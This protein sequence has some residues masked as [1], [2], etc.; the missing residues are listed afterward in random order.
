MQIWMQRHASRGGPGAVTWRMRAADTATRRLGSSRTRG[1]VLALVRSI[2]RQLP[3]AGVAACFFASGMAGLVYEVVWTRLL[4]LLFGHTVHAVT[5]VLA[6]Y[7]G[8]L[9]LGSLLLGRWADRVRRPLRA[10]AGLDALVGAYCAATP[11]LLSAADGAYLRLAR[12]ANPSGAAAL[13]LQFLLAAALLAVPT[14][15]MGATLPV[16]SRAV[17]RGGEAAAPRV[18]LL[19][20]VNTC[21]AVLGTVLTGLVLLP[22]IGLRATVGIGVALDLAA[23]AVALALDRLV[24]APEEPPPTPPEV[25]PAPRAPTP[26]ARGPVPAPVAIALVSAGVAG[27]AS[28]AYEIAWTRALSL[29]LGSS[30]YAFTAM[31]ATFLVGLAVGAL[32]AAR[33]LRGR[34]LG[35]GTFAA[36][37]LAV[38]L[39]AVLLLPAFGWLPALALRV[40]GHTGV[41]HGAALSV[42][43]A[44]SFAVVIVP[45]LL[46]GATFPVMVS[47]L[48]R[49][50]GRLGQDVGAVYGASTLGTIAGSVAAGFLLVPALGIQRTVLVAA[51]ANLCAGV[52]LLA[53]AREVRRRALAGAAVACFAAAAV[54]VPRWDAKVMTSG[55]SV[56]AEQ[57]LAKGGLEP[58]QAE[59]E[60]LLYSEGISTTVA[61]E[62]AGDVL[63]VRVNGKVDAGNDVDM[64]TQLLLG[65]LGALLHPSPRRVLIVGL[66]SGVTAGA[67]AQHPVE[68]IDV[69]E[70]EP[71]MLRASEFFLKENRGV[72]H[73]PR[74]RLLE[75]DGR[76]I[77][78]AAPEPYDLV[79]SEP[80][81]PWIAGIASLFT[82]DFYEIARER[83]SSGGVFVQWLQGYGIYARDMQMVVRTF[84][85]VFPHVSVWTAAPGDFLLVATPEPL[86]V[87]VAAL[88]RR[89]AAS[90]GVRDDFERHG[91]ARG[92]LLFRFLLDEEG[93]RRFAAGAPLN[94]DDRPL[95]EF[96]APL[97]LYAHPERANL[98]VMRASR[99]ALRP[100]V[101][102]ID[103]ASLSGPAAS[104]R[105]AR[106]HWRLGWPDDAL[107]ELQRAGPPEALGPD[108]RLERGRLLVLLGRHEQAVSELE[109]LR[110]DAPEN[111]VVAQYLRAALDLRRDPVPASE[112][113]A[114][115]V[116]R[117]DAGREPGYCRLAIDQLEPDTA[118][119]PRTVTALTNT[120][121]ALYRLGEL[122]RAEAALRRALADD[123]K[124]A[125]T[126]L[127]LG[128][129][130]EKQGRIAAAAEAFREAIR[131]DPAQAAARRHLAGLEAG[132]APVR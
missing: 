123:P 12:A 124:L 47:A 70:L 68:R 81:N 94:T 76:H 18:A 101:T 29:V 24:A 95:L 35:L 99:V 36:L 129:V 34:G 2:S 78:A 46:I 37:Q 44:L 117:C 120:A 13:A 93:A 39:S 89:V 128:L 105:A 25:T 22:A 58:V 130:L 87:D 79:I 73:D 52:A 56:Y 45:T 122:G 80:S 23:A 64:P 112:L 111:S 97:A 92:G 103:P 106:A 1:N 119:G 41:S 28:M 53:A 16:L 77:L 86:R 109:A 33:L 114:V 60:L 110:R 49:G 30:T 88:E 55:V 98:A 132:P 20:G 121:G 104:L 19:Y 43:F 6:A 71:A 26:A 100:P 115:L 107:D 54:L 72:M 108:A 82:R 57:Y 67:V 74:V 61:V 50:P 63:G 14:T 102:G 38:A 17:V 8:G 40:L 66:A 62:R 90:P 65:H 42:Q 21:G 83:M 59:R 7:M 113:R 27:A 96:R 125:T 127:D 51:S 69:A 11:L 4:G 116:D 10:Y 48:A 5:T 31:L 118:A 91:W 75:G 3:V 84:Q 85:Q 131:L 32:V 9:A 15:L 126:H